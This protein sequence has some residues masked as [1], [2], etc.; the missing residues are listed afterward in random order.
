VASPPGSHVRVTVMEEERMCRFQD[1][2][3]ISLPSIAIITSDHQRY[4]PRL[5]M[6]RNLVAPQSADA[7]EKN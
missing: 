4:F 1:R 7:I 6:I 2:F 5:W 3:F